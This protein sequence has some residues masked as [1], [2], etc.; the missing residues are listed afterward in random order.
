[1]AFTAGRKRKTERK[2]QRLRVGL[3]ARGCRRGAGAHVRRR[4]GEAP[5][6]DAGAGPGLRDASA[7]GARRVGGQGVTRGRHRPDV[8]G[9]TA[10]VSGRWQPTFGPTALSGVAS[11]P[12]IPDASV[13]AEGR[14]HG[15]RHGRRRA[16]RRPWWPG[17]RCRRGGELPPL[18]SALPAREPRTPTLPRNATSGV[19]AAT[20]RAH[21]GRNWVLDRSSGSPEPALGAS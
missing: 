1:M 5:G 3:S 17:S 16:L 12:A 2:R 19:R 21:E 4:N 13:P 6:L 8:Y 9:R 14:R 20:A 15:V 18:R 7:V 10:A 11:W